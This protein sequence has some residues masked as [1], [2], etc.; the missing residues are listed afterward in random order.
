MLFDSRTKNRWISLAVSALLLV[1]YC[2]VAVVLG[3]RQRELMNADAV[4]YIRRAQY[5]LNGQFYYFLSEHWSLMLSGL[6]APLMA[7]KIDGL[8]AARIVL[9][10]VGAVYMVCFILLARRLLKVHWAWH[11]V[12]GV[13]LAPLV[14]AM[15]MRA[16][17]PDLLLAVW[18]VIYFLI[19]LH[20]KLLESSGRQFLAGV[21]GGFAYLAKSFGL[22]FVLAHLLMTLILLISRRE[23]GAVAVRGERLKKLSFA[24]ARG[25]LGFLLIAAPWIGALSWKYHHLTFGSAGAAAHGML[26][27]QD[28][29]EASKQGWLMRWNLEVPT[30]P[31]ITI[32]ENPEKLYPRWSPFASKAYF[33]HQCTIIR[34]HALD[35][36]HF[37]D[38]MAALHVIPALV[39]VSLALVL[40]RSPQRWKIAWLLL[41]L[42]LFLAPFLVV[43]INYR[44]L[45]PHIVPLVLLLCLIVVLEWRR[46]TESSESPTPE[47]A[48][49]HWAR[50]VGA[51]LICG[52]FAWG[53]Y[54]WM[55]PM[56]SSR[57][58]DVYRI[59]GHKINQKG[60]IGP[61]ACDDTTR[62][63][64]IAYHSGDKYAGFPDTANPQ[65][66]AN[67]LRQ[68]GIEYVVIF[69]VSRGRGGRGSC[70]PMM[71]E[72]GGW[73]Q[74]IRYRGASVY[75]DDPTAPPKTRPTTDETMPADDES[76]EDMEGE[77]DNQPPH[78]KATAKTK[79]QRRRGI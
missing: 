52:S 78:S 50:G 28:L 40:F 3:L 79:K 36:V 20:P 24:Y 7:L 1:V 32:T 63:F 77:L 37:L 60:L 46:G 26:A 55:K 38:L 33:Q 51:L 72:R 2:T 22:P 49:L 10:I 39:L 68:A 73:R 21:V 42:I 64:A 76:M 35:L 17:T 19:V 67:R 70:A 44:Y 48:P 4:N 75:R 71:V 31:Y 45:G 29:P 47:A 34:R 56:L 59:L 65:E 6:I 57:A 13:V 58:S 27:P 62:A 61:F 5:L 15:A 30:G 54:E 53:A 18:L 11:C 23:E 25:L 9:G 8:Y 43:L 16:I 66:A 41:T 12:A 74:V 14:A 69:D